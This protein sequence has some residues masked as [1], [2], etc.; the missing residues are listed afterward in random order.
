MADRVSSSVSVKCW[1]LGD[2]WNQKLM[3]LGM[4]VQ[5]FFQT[6][7]ASESCVAIFG[8]VGVAVEGEDGR[9]QL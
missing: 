4:L 7:D 3:M 6:A 5:F 9:Q 8:R 2:G 1:Q